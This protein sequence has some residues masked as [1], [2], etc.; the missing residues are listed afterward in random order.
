MKHI[1]VDSH[2]I[3]NTLY[4]ILQVNFVEITLLFPLP[5]PSLS[6]IT[7]TTL[8]KFTHIHVIT[9]IINTNQTTTQFMVLLLVPAVLEHEHR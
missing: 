4:D 3:S 6:S 9:N 8:H 2:P 5:T 1:C 7:K